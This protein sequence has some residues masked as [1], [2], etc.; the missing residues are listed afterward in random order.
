MTIK[1]FIKHNRQ[2]IDLH[3]KAQCSNCKI[4]NKERE[5]WISNDESLYNWA[6]A[7]GVNFNE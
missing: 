7:V 2:D 4:N 5:D 1:Q 6:K 3:I